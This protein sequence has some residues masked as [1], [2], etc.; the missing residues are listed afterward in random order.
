MQLRHL[1]G[2]E[3]LTLAPHHAAPDRPPVLFVHGNWHGAWCWEGWM[4]AFAEAGWTTHALS[5][6]GHG[7]SAP[8]LMEAFLALDAAAMAQAVGRVA[9]AIGRRCVLV[10]HSLGGL[11]SQAVAARDGAAA[12]VLVASAAPYG[13]STPRPPFPADRPVV[14]SPEAAAQ[15]LFHNAEPVTM[16]AA[17]AR[18]G[19]ASPGIMNSSG[20]RL[21]VDVKRVTCPVL[22]VWPMEDRSSVPPG[23][24]LA[25]A[26]GAEVLA[27]PG[28]GHDLMFERAG[29]TAL[30]GILGWLHRLTV[31]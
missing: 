27:I 18:L 23:R 24:V 20:G 25:E 5:L 3:W 10:G 30:A 28:A 1:D 12:L 13:L 4:R 6:P 22:V 15:L 16:R 11:L 7:S 26:Y 9:A 17:I 21:R 29:A 8:M 19:P 14:L 2:M 31:R